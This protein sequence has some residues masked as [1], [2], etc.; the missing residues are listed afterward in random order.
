MY[1]Y[2]I[3][4]G[5]LTKMTYP[6]CFAALKIQYLFFLLACPEDLFVVFWCES[7]LFVWSICVICRAYAAFFIDTCRAA[8][9]QHD[10]QELCRVMFDALERS[11]KHTDQENLITQLYQGKIKDYVK[12]LQVTISYSV[13]GLSSARILCI[14]CYCLSIGWAA[15]YVCTITSGC[16]SWVSHVCFWNVTA[17]T[18]LECFVDR[19]K[20]K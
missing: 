13:L 19:E 16:S 11:W 2:F 9:Q 1:M 6:L 3:C 5:I 8:W 12:C 15:S 10:V 20:V 4:S 18:N 17:E 7:Y 14:C